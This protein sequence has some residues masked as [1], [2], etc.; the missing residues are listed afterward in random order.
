MVGATGPTGRFVTQELLHA[1]YKVHGTFRTTPPTSQANTEVMYFK[2]DCTLSKNLELAARGC[3]ALISCVHLSHA[4]TLLQLAADFGIQ[5]GL[6]FS[7]ARIH[8]Q[9]PDPVIEQLNSAEALIMASGLDYTIVRPTM[10]YGHDNDRNLFPIYERVG[11]KRLHFLPNGGA[12]LVQ[13]VHVQDV[14]YAVRLLLEA[15]EA[16]M[17]T[18]ELAGPNPTTLRQ[19]LNEMANAQQRNIKIFSVPIWIVD[20]M[21]RNCP[22]NLLPKG[23]TK[24]AVMRLKEDVVVDLAETQQLIPFLPR[25]FAEGVCSYKTEN[26]L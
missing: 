19:I 13:P 25:S 10:I 24:E 14:A 9:I 21:V 6:F 7:S 17:K 18:V 11:K 15:P 20:F 22:P 12:K 4:K 16:V 2:A 8:S 5:R 23:L 1:R 26:A 3:E